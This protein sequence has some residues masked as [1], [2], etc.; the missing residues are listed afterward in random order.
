[1]LGT[2]SA[3][4][5]F[6]GVFFQVFFFSQ[7]LPPAITPQPYRN[8]TIIKSHRTPP[9]THS[10]SI[11]KLSSPLCTGM[12]IAPTLTQTGWGG[13]G[14]WSS[15]CPRPSPTVTSPLQQRPPLSRHPSTLPSASR[16]QSSCSLTYL[17]HTLTSLSLSHLHT[18]THTLTNTP[19]LPH[20]WSNVFIYCLFGRS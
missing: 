15:L 10:Q 20:S 18:G 1:M 9:W 19:M 16:P 12:D 5:F 4:V 6:S 7:P 3:N 11:C 14:A 17:P 2:C 13:G 8:S